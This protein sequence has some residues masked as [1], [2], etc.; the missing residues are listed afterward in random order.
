MIGFIFLHRDLLEWEWYQNPE[1]SRLYIHILLKA[2]FT[3]KKWQG[4]SVKRGQFI[5]SSNHLASDLNLS[6]Q[7]IR[8]ALKKLESSGYITRQTTNKFTLITIVNYN[9]RQHQSVLTNKQ[10]ITQTQNKQLTNNN[11]PT[12]TK[13]SNKIKNLNKEKIELRLAKFKKQ[14]FEHSQYSTKI[15]N[16]FFNY[17]SEFNT[18]KTKMKYESQRGFFEIERRLKKWT[19]NEWKTTNKNNQQKNTISNR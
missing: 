8:T 17:W 3:D 5:T 1:V 15:L 7:K 11:P 19:E 12:T 14:V 18:A 4:I 2:N 9:N 16:A 10:K 13:E 6:I